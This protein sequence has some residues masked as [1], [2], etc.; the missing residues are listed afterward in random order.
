MGKELTGED[1]IRVL[2][3]E[4]HIESSWTIGGLQGDF[5]G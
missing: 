4:T 2:G 3:A 1:L 5:T